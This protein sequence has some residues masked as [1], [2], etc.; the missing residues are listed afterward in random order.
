MV[1]HSPRFLR[2]RFSNLAMPVTVLI[3]LSRGLS[4]RTRQVVSAQTIRAAAGQY[5]L[6]GSRT[7]CGQ[8]WPHRLR[9]APS[10][11]RVSSLS[12]SW[13]TKKSVLG[14]TVTTKLQSIKVWA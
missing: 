13:R 9:Q 2:I 3:T 10:C 11:L 8:F 1:L 14:D 5:L 7:F 12:L 4:G 6:G